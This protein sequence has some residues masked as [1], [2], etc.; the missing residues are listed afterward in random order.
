[1]LKQ[2]KRLQNPQN[3][4]FFCCC[5]RSPSNVLVKN[6]PKPKTT[7]KISLTATLKIKKGN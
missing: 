4:S 7:S 3:T 5:D 1:M 2:N 6:E